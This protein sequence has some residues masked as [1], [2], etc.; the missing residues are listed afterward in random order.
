MKSLSF[1]C[2]SFFSLLLLL[3]L[4]FGVFTFLSRFLGEELIIGDSSID[5]EDDVV[6]DRVN[7]LFLGDDDDALILGDDDD[8]ELI[9]RDDDDGELILGDVDI[10][11]IEIDNKR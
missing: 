1:S 6:V 4:L 3:L 10:L 5:E 7:G 11:L 2:R 8:G 9:L